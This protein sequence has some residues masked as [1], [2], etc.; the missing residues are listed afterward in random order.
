M[1]A[2]ADMGFL[3]GADEISVSYLAIFLTAFFAAF[4][5][6]FLATFFMAFFGAA[7]LAAFFAAFLVA[8]LYIDSPFKQIR[9]ALFYYNGKLSFVARKKF[10]KRRAIG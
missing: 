7:F 6:A 5:V 3:I 10:D 4:F 2:E 8:I 1:P 9:T